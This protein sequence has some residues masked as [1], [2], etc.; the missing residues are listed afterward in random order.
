VG[1][2]FL[3]PP[4]FVWLAPLLPLFFLSTFLNMGKQPMS[5]FDASLVQLGRVSSGEKWWKWL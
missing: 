3:K 2:F 1:D 5:L 4:R